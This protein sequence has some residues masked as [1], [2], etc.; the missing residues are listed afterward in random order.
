MSTKSLGITVVLSRDKA[1]MALEPLEAKIG[2]L[3]AMA[4]MLHTTDAE[5]RVI[6]YQQWALEAVRDGIQVAL[7]QEGGG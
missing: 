3:K 5:R 4:N 6:E 2:R 7:A 1:E